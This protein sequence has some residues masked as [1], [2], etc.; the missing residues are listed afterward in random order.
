MRKCLA[1]RLES[2]ESAPPYM[3]DPAHESSPHFVPEERFLGEFRF[4]TSGPYG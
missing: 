2:G 4:K 3:D 1:F